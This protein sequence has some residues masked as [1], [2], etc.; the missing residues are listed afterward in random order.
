MAMEAL[1]DDGY[2][3]FSG[4]HIKRFYGDVGYRGESG[5]IHANVTLAN[6]KFGVSGPAPVD[7]TNLDESAVFTTPQTIKNTLSMFDINGVF[8]ATPTWK[9]FGD[10]HYR[11]F[12]QARVDGNTTEFE[13]GSRRV[14]VRERRRRHKHPQFF[15]R[16]GPSGGDR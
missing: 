3:Q 11:A 15:Q 10:V 16:A 14:A 9:L 4:A 6:N 13:C 12:D 8:Q 5:E 2:R 7:L 1:G